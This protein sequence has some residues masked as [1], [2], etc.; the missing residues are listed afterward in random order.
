MVSDF[1]CQDELNRTVASAQ[2]DW[3]TRH[4]RGIDPDGQLIGKAE[5]RG[6]TPPNSMPVM[7]RVSSGVAKETLRALI[8]LWTRLLKSKL[9]V[10]RTTQATS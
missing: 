9:V 10:A 7:H 5:W 8:F 4:D 3:L 1:L 6:V 2:Y